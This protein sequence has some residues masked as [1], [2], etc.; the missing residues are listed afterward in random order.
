MFLSQFCVTRLP[1]A[2]LLKSVEYDPSTSKPEY[3]SDSQMERGLLSNSLQGSTRKGEAEGPPK[4]PVYIKHPCQMMVIILSG[5]SEHDAQ[6]RSIDAVI[7]FKASLKF[8]S[9]RA[10]SFRRAPIFLSY[11]ILKVPRWKKT[12]TEI[13]PVLPFRPGSEFLL[14]RTRTAGR[15]TRTELQS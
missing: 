10:A 4:I 11:H 12:S 14:D 5:S 1:L 8:S 2:V 9:K 13:V 7:K 15:P 3:L 6:M